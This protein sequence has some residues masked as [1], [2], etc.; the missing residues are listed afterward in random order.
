VIYSD[1]GGGHPALRDG[2]LAQ[3]RNALV[4]GAGFGCVHYAVEVPKGPAGQ[5]WLDW[6]G[7]YFETNWSVNP[8][9]TP[10]FNPLPSHPITRGVHPFS[11]RDEWYYHMRFRPGMR[12]VTPLLSALPPADTLKRRDGAHSNN[13]AVRAAV[14]ER[15]E[16]QVVMWAAKRPDDSRSFGFTGGHY[17]RNWGQDD[18]RKI[19]LNALLWVSGLDVPPQGVASHVTPED[20]R[21]NLDRKGR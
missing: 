5:D 16:P 3:L 21:Q 14:L 9:W 11:V 20:L 10:Q 19:V 2:H 13:P 12:E 1:G 17:H 18:F 6:L 15:H 8:F 4:R 7:G